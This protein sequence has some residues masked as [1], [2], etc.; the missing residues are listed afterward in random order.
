MTYTLLIGRLGVMFLDIIMFWL[1][2]EG[3]QQQQSTLAGEFPPIWSLHTGS[4]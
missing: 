2:V 1:A 4:S 3:E